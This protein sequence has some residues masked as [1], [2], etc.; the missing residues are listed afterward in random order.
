MNNRVFA[1][2][3]YDFLKEHDE[4]GYYTDTA[5]EDCI[6]ELENY[7]DDIH[8]VQESIKDIEEIA[9]SFDNH[10]VY[11]TDVKPLLKGLREIQ[12]ELEAKASKRMI[13]DTGYEVKQSFHLNGKDILLAENKNAEDGQFYLVCQYVENGIIGEYSQAATD[14]DYL[15]VLREFTGRVNKEITAV[16][17]ER[18]ALNL[19]ADLFTVEHCHPN[20]YKES[21]VGMVVAIKSSVF[22]PEYRRGDNQLVLVVGGNGAS[23]NP[24]GNAV[25]CNH[26]NNGAHTRFE[27]YEVLGVVRDLPDWAKESLARLQ[28]ELEKPAAEKK[29]AGKY[30]IIENIEVGQKVFA[31]GHNPGAVQPYGTWQSYK[32]SSRG[33]DDGHYFSTHEDAKNDLQRR[34]GQEQKRLDSPKRSDKDNR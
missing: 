27:R 21:L 16:Q 12:A 23:A 14:G 1:E 31:L 22:S 8:M 30:E 4:R 11:I 19:P 5:P 7:L 25:Y 34:A 28:S 26:L 33:F 20:D 29:Y 15:E 13:G 3:L 32:E 17:A 9:D 6:A 10:E 2:E 24:N 18:D